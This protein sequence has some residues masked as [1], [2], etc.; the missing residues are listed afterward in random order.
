MQTE[1]KHKIGDDQLCASDILHSEPLPTHNSCM[2]GICIVTISS[3]F[4][5]LFDWREISMKQSVG[6]CKQINF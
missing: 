2:T 1:T 3:T 4:I 5:A 6:T